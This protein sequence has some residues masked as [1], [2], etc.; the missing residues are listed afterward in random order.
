MNKD[1]IF[2]TGERAVQERAGQSAIADRNVVVLSDSVIAGARPFIAKQFMVALGTVDAKGAVWASLV[3]G[4]PGFLHTD[5]GSVIDMTVPPAE[6]DGWDPLW[7]NIGDGVDGPG[8]TDADIGMLFI[9]LGTRRR[10]RVNGSVSRLDA[11]GV[12]VTVSEA[13]PNCPK[14]I[15]RRELRSRGDGDGASAIGD[16]VQRG[17]ALTAALA[18]LFERAD[19]VFLASHHP[20][21]GADVSHRGGNA[22][23]VNMVGERTLRLPDYHGNSLFS[24]LGNFQV[25]ARMGLCVPDFA[26]RKLLQLTGS[27]KLL[28]DQD[29]PH[30]ETGG[31]RRFLELTIDTWVLRDMA[32]QLEWE[33]LDASPYLPHQH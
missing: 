5:D 11:T 31:T 12:G 25:D 29:D 32:Q 6:R 14:Y 1:T 26:G 28:W 20:R 16:T 27:A 4:K 9:E 18:P 17:T 19:T 15:Q 22:G 33:Y 24:T 2:H 13:F 10:Y 21:T 30:N 3:F 8:A 7:D 23:F